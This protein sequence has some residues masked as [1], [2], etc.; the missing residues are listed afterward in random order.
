MVKDL[1]SWLAVGAANPH[2]DQLVRLEGPIGLGN[3]GVGESR[4]AYLHDRLERMSP[5]LE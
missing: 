1:A 3:D 2:L 4:L 5:A